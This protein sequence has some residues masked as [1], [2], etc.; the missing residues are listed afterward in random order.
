MNKFYKFEKV[1]EDRYAVWYK[2][3]PKDKGKLGVWSIID[4]YPGTRPTR[5]AFRWRVRGKEKSQEQLDEQILA[6]IIKNFDRCINTYRGNYAKR[7][8][9]IKKAA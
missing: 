8:M 1:I 5:F 3:T 9:P 2:E 4:L 7:N 6:G